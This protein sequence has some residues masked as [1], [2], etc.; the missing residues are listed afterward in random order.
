MN[1]Y[2][3]EQFYKDLDELNISLQYSQ[4]EQFIRYYEML[5]EKNKVMNLTAITDFD[6]VLKKH[7]VDSLS[8]VKA[9]DLNQSGD[10]ITLIDIGTEPV[11][12]GYRLRL[13]FRI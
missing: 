6:E 7:F 3:L 11:F 10:E 4:V 9:Y 5:I 1:K 2:N 12:R 8:L 13:L